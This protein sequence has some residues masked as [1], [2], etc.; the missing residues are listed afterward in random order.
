MIPNIGPKILIELDLPQVAIDNNIDKEFEWKPGHEDTPFNGMGLGAEPMS[1]APSPLTGLPDEGLGTPHQTSNS[2]ERSDAD[3]SRRE[4]LQHANRD[5]DANREAEKTTRG[6]ERITG[7]EK[8]EDPAAKPGT[9]GRENLKLQQALRTAQR[10]QKA[11]IKAGIQSGNTE[12]SSQKTQNIRSGK[13]QTIQFQD[14]TENGPDAIRLA[15]SA[16]RIR[17]GDVATAKKLGRVAQAISKAARS[18]I[19]KQAT[20]SNINTS[21]ID[22]L[23]NMN[24]GETSTL[25]NN[26]QNQQILTAKAATPANPMAEFNEWMKLVN[27]N[28]SGDAVLRLQDTE[29]GSLEVR[30][31]VDGK[32]L[33]IAL[34]A[35][36]AAMRERMLQD[37]KEVHRQLDDEGLVEGNVHVG[38]FGTS[39]GQND[40]DQNQENDSDPQ[41][42]LG[43]NQP[44]KTRNIPGHSET[45][46][47]S[48]KIGKLH[49]LA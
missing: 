33:F 43:L 46:E 31:R 48:T 40:F 24:V 45:I 37:I 5:N 26:Q 9:P 16:L 25:S 22:N 12:E 3:L 11:A 35:E 19:D 14:K 13:A 41:N 30:V 21:T 6:D 27:T 34:R 36:D 42:N 28:E 20:G 7:T 4:P 17:K 38:E 23:S 15:Q 29:A 18:L 10:A 47:T 1:T 49:I 2:A 8:T 32:D 44:N 39:E